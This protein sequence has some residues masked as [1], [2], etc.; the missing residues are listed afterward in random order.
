MGWPDFTQAVLG[1]QGADL[2]LIDTAQRLNP[3]HVFQPTLEQAYGGLL[4]ATEQLTAGVITVTVTPNTLN[5]PSWTQRQV[6]PGGGAV[7][8]F[9]PPYPMIPGS[10]VAVTI[11]SSPVQA[12]AGNTLIYGLGVA[13]PSLQGAQLLR[14]DGR[15]Y[16]V[17]A[18]SAS[19]NNVAGA[20]A[21][22]APGAGVHIL[23]A[24]G[25]MI[26]QAAAAAG[27]T[28]ILTATVN[29]AAVN[30]CVAASANGAYTGPAIVVPP[31]GLLCD[32]NTA[33]TFTTAGAPQIAQ[34]NL[35]YDL[36]A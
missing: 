35:V 26:V 22:P 27:S 17:G 31:G 25:I 23:L 15:P 5:A 21:I 11:T 16:P 8:D 3:S 9:C 33:V 32:A 19:V 6:N 13:P 14:A 28:A 29:G 20:T 30:I 36:A 34:A 24:S 7:L 1:Y 18:L 4:I 12:V 10:T 2:L